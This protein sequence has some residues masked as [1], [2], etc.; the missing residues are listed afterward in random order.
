MEQLIDLMTGFYAGPVPYLVVFVIL[1]GCGLGLPVPEDI[2]L[3]FAGLTAYYGISTLWGMLIL[4]FAG[5]LIGDCTIF[6]LGAK[7]GRR[8]TRVKFFGRFLTEERLRL[9]QERFHTSGNKLIF[10]ARFMPGLRAPVFFTAGV[11]HLP[12]R[13]FFFYDGLAAL[14]SAPAII[15]AVYFFGDQIDLVIKRVQSVEHGILAMVFGAAL[16]VTAKWY[17]TKRKA[18]KAA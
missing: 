18:A 11:L 9:V 1:L 6:Y 2:T 16:F 5:I 15:L 14:L 12:F 3:I 8:I 10:I 13:V 7:Y 17:L 4:C